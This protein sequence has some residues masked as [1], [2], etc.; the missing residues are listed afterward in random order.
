MNQAVPENRFLQGI[1]APIDQEYSL[2]KLRITGEVPKDLNGSFYRHRI[3]LVLLLT[4][5]LSQSQL[6]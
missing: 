1:F 4:P 2:D 6:R 5:H 3:L